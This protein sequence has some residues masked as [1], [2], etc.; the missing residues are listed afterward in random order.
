MLHIDS[1]VTS[2]EVF[3]ERLITSNNISSYHF[4]QA[5]IEIKIEVGEKEYTATLQTGH[6]YHHGD[7]SLPSNQLS[8]YEGSDLLEQLDASSESDLDSANGV[9]YINEE[10]GT[11]YTKEE[12]QAIHAELNDIMITAQQDVTSAETEADEKLD[13][14]N[15]TYVLHTEMMNEEVDDGV[16]EKKQCTPSY[17]NKYDTREEAQSFVDEKEALGDIAYI[18]SKEQGQTDHCEHLSNF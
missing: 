1:E 12:L 13:D 8:V 3:T 7:Y 9:E 5:D 18:V 17:T 11:N 15:S 6:S 2:S 16:F 10:S 4:I 14:D